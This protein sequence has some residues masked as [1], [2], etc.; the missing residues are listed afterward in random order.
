[1]LIGRNILILKGNSTAPLVHKGGHI[2]V[3]YDKADTSST[4]FLPLVSEARTGDVQALAKG[5]CAALTF[6]S[7]HANGRPLIVRAKLGTEIK[8]S[9]QTRDPVIARE[10]TGLATAHLERLYEALRWKGI[11]GGGQAMGVF[12]PTR[13]IE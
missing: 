4:D 11:G 1:L 9:L 6:P 8:F 7:E 5:Q 13:R 12:H 10:R 3:A 2:G